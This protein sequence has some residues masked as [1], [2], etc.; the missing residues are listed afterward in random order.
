[1]ALGLGGVLV[2]ALR[3]VTVRV[4]PISAVEARGALDSLRGRAILSGVRGAPPADIEALADMASRLSWLAYDLR[5][6][7]EE[8]DLNPVLVLAEGQGAVAVDALMVALR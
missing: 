4:P 7:I 5:D 1:M 6:G 3:D 8:L 2:E